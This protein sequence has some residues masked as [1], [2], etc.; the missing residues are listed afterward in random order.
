MSKKFKENEYKDIIVKSF[1]NVDDVNSLINEILN[2]PGKSDSL[3]VYAKRDLISEL[4][5]NLIESGYDFDYVDLDR[6]DDLF[7]DKIYIMTINSNYKVNIESAYIDGQVARHKSTIVL[8]Y[9]DECKQDIIDYCID[10]NM[11]VILFDFEEYGGYCE[12]K[13]KILRSY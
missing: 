8:F 12:I 2:K 3:I 11:K 4:F 7:K 6:I 9:A 5:I 10:E 13:D 1:Y